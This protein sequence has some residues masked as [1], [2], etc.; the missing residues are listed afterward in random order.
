MN[1]CNSTEQVTES[2]DQIGK[3][4]DSMECSR[5]SEDTN[6]EENISKHEGVKYACSL[7]DYQGTGTASILEHISKAIH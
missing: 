5:V 6:I 4:E 3:N 7:C 2:T 1:D